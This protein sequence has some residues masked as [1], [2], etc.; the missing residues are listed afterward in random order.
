MPNVLIRDVDVAVL[1]RLK[2]RAKGQNRSLQAELNNV[3]R[4]SANRP[5][6][7][8]ELELIREI[9]ASIKNKQRTD[10]VELLREDRN[11]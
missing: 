4:D 1:N 5:D 11:R 9:R 7:M 8:S 6:P 2:T 3:L 10:S